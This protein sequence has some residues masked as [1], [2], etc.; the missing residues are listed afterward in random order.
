METDFSATARSAVLLQEDPKGGPNKFLGCCA[1]KNDAAAANYSSNKGELAA[2]ILGLKKY[3]HILSWKKFTIITDN[4]CV[5]FIRN[6]KNQK[7]I[8]SRWKEILASYDFDIIHRPGRLHFFADSLSRRTDLNHEDDVEDDIAAEIL[9]VYNIVDELTLPEDATLEGFGAI[10]L[11]ELQAETAADP[12]LNKV[13]PF[14]RRG[15]PPDEENCR[16]KCCP[17]ST[18]SPPYF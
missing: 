14:V 5:S 17:I 3:E 7:G 10:P 2:V 9:D 6:L 4:A 11:G 12:V 15:T 13:L 18:G 16:W 1:A 8:Y